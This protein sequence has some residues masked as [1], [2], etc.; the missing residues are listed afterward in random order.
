MTGNSN[1][2]ETTLARRISRR[3]A[4]IGAGSLGAGPV[5]AACGGGDDGA[6]G[7][8]SGKAEQEGTPKPGGTWRTATITLSP[9][10]SPYH[11]GAD[12]SAHQNWRRING[13]YD[14]L[15][16][17]RNTTDPA[18]L[19]YPNLASSIEQVD[20]LT[21]IVK[22]QRAFYHDQPQSKSNA[23]VQARQATAEDF[24]ASFEFMKA[25]QTGEILASAIS[26]GKDLKS[27]TAIDQT[28]VRYDM[29][30][31]LA[32]FYESGS[33]GANAAYAIPR[34]MLET[35]TIKQDIPIGTG[36]FMFKGYQQGSIEEAVRNPN[37]FLKDR[38]F[39]DGKKLT[40][41]PDDAAQE[42]AFRANQID[43][44]GFSNIRQRDSVA[45]DLGDR[46]K[47]V[48]TL[49]G[50]T[51]IA[52]MVNIHRKPFDDVRVREA[53]YRAVNVQRIID[54]VFFGDA[55]RSWFFADTNY[56]RFPLGYQAVEKYVSYDPK[57][58]ADLMRAAA[59]DPNKTYEIMLPAQSQT[60]VDSGRL[61]AE[62]WGKVGM[63]V[64]NDPQVLS[65]YLSRAGPKPG[66]FDIT[67]GV[68]QDY[69]AA[70]TVP[71]YFWENTGLE[72][73]EMDA[74]IEQIYGAVDA[75]K[76][77]ELSQ[78]FEL[79]LAQKYSNFMPMLVPNAHTG[80]YSFIKGR[81]MEMSNTGLGG[82]QPNIW[83]D[84]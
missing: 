61:A 11:R 70:R 72:D 24:A 5:L 40:F 56:E 41:V 15:W 54:V 18:R 51:G 8:A 29:Y 1:Y 60:W 4:L 49:G 59:V 84:R 74:I 44:F 78:K 16:G 67:M 34:E 32:F 38:P 45:A 12:P 63:K 13:Y 81:D 53:M 73:A 69:R 62:D 46:I 23:K 82:W 58:A 64:K 2:W 77:K 10:F 31:P 21:V 27:V 65:I 68:F 37:Y 39:L 50:G 9:H 6:Q 7:G 52:F 43:S 22:M 55:V 76:R 20:E 42:A 36:P 35:D 25:G 17:L 33:G 71:G 19:V 30:R 66:D 57:K 80:L 75:Q 14:K 79:M 48:D 3:R 28:T 47:V 26:T 83:F